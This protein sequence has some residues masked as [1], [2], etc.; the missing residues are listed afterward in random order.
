MRSTILLLIAALFPVLAL[1]SAFPTLVPLQRTGAP[2]AARS[3]AVCHFQAAGI[4]SGPNIGAGS[5]TLI[6]LPSSYEAN[7][8]IIDVTIVLS[9]PGQQ[10]WGFQ[11][12]AL[13][14]YQR[15]AGSI[16]LP[17]N[18]DK[19]MVEIITDATSTPTVDYLMHS[20]R[21]A[22]W[23]PSKLG[24]P[25]YWRFKW[26]PPAAGDVTFY[27]ASVAANGDMETQGDRVYTNKYSITGPP[28]AP[29]DISNDGVI[30]YL[31]WFLLAYRWRRDGGG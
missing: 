25:V 15:Q 7:G 6:G 1:G 2:P 3:C 20:W 21:G 23:D 13:S 19:Q 9:D 27:I 30:N 29:G 4:P 12:V 26:Q 14:E 17:P 18:P 24:G 11:L 22:Y 31:D 28:Y 8:P 16:L 10:R 5:I